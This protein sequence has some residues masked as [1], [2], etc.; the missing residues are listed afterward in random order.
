MQLN[1]AFDVRMLFFSDFIE[2]QLLKQIFISIA[3][4]LDLHYAKICE[5]SSVLSKIKIR[6]RGCAGGQVEQRGQSKCGGLYFFCGRGTENYRLGTIY[7]YTT[8]G[9]QQLKEWCLLEKGF[10]INS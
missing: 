3:Q 1:I 2:Y 4:N 7:M 10:H 6:L 8:E 9:V 5:L